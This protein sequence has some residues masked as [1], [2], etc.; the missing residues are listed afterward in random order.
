MPTA[1]VIDGAY[2]LRRFHHC[3]PKLNASDP[4]QLLLG[5]GALVGEH[6]RYRLSDTILDDG[7][8]DKQR[9]FVESPEL[10]RIFFYDCPPLEKRVHRPIS[11]AALNLQFTPEAQLRLAL[12]GLLRDHRKVALRMGRLSQYRGWRLKNESAQAWLSGKSPIVLTDE[13]FEIDITQKG[14]DMRLGLDVAAM[15]FKK[16]VT[17]IVM[18]TGDSDFVPAVKLARRE[19]IDVVL[20]PMLGNVSHDLSEHVDGRRS[21]KFSIAADEIA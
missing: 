17:Q 6:M 11:K 1:F 5:L 19:G 7:L 8:T 12:H 13:D 21:F 10:Y 9:N 16:Q 3:F 15:S 14:V 18:V 20:D 4:K 2:F